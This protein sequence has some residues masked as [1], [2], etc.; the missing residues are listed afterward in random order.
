MDTSHITRMLYYFRLKVLGI[1]TMKSG[2][3]SVGNK[4]NVKKDSGN[5]LCC[6]VSVGMVI[7]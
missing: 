2:T 7:P 5:C 3:R 6:L 4:D 1:A